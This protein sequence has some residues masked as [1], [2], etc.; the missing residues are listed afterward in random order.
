MGK[1]HLSTP[2]HV[3]LQ[4]T[5]RLPGNSK[6]VCWERHLSSPSRIVLQRM[7][8]LSEKS[9]SV[10]RSV[11]FFAIHPLVA[12]P[13]LEGQSSESHFFEDQ[14]FG[15]QLFVDLS[16][17]HVQHMCTESPTPNSYRT[18]ATDHVKITSTHTIVTPR[19]LTA[20][21]RNSPNLNRKTLK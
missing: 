8:R 16:L 7:A 12:H 5:A 11:A 17:F 10:R 6:N 2:S 1:C 4:Q 20:R 21:R 18:F 3:T 9:K 19:K 13:S 14:S 15:S